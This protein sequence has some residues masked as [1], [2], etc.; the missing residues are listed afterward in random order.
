GRGRGS[1]TPV[2]AQFNRGGEMMM[3]DCIKD[4][5]ANS[6]K[7]IIGGTG[8]GKSVKLVEEAMAYIAQYNPRVFIIEKGDSF[9]LLTEYLARQG[10]KTHSIK[11]DARSNSILP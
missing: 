7:V 11:L 5:Q 4:R 6:H 9:K 8:A 3:F 1:G 2:Q 10:K